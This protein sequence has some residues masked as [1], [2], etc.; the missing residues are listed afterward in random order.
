MTWTKVVEYLIPIAAFVII[1]GIIYFGSEGGLWGKTVELSKGVKEMAPNV[2]FGAEES[3]AGKPI[4]AET[5]GEEAINSL[6]ETIELMLKKTNQNCFANYGGLP[7][8]EKGTSIRFIYDGGS[9]TTMIIKAKDGKQTVEMKEF[10]GMIPCVIAQGVGENFYYTFLE[11]DLNKVNGNTFFPVSNINILLDDGG[12]TG[13]TE[14]RIDY[15]GGP[16]D[17]EDGAWLFTPGKGYICFLPTEDGNAECDGLG[18]EG[19]DDDCTNDVTE[20]TTI[21]Y[22]VNNQQL[23][24][25]Q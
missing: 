4:I 18:S 2:T 10:P 15:G 20:I 19:L 7:D 6:G 17:F 8:F 9:K 22:R 16:I 24:R 12:Y 11:P 14:N 1:V 25:C 13:L 23:V 21:P 3:K 5:G